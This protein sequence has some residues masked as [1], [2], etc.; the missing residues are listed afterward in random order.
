M[1]PLH[2]ITEE[3]VWQEVPNE[4]SLAF[5]CSGCP[6]ACKGC[7][8]AYSWAADRGTLLSADYLENRLDRY[9]DLISCVLF[10]GGEWEAAALQQLLMICQ[11]RNLKTCLYTGLEMAEL[12]A[13]PVNILPH[14]TYLKT[15]RWIE[16]LGGLDCPTTNQRFL[17]V[18]TGQNL[19]YLF[20]KGVQS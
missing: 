3:I 13:L 1:Y 14:L 19:N 4:V 8:S 7:H 15:G 17:D 20:Q 9:R 16:S 5:L 2:F 6:L 12:S 10:L 18:R 11:Q